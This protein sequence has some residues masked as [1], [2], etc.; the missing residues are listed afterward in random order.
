[1]RPFDRVAGIAAPLLKPNIDTDMIIRV[2]HMTASDQSRLGDHAFETWRIGPDGK[3]YPDF[4]LNQPRYRNAPILLAGANFG[5]GSSREHAVSALLG[6]GI[7]VVIA[8]DFGE[9]FYNNCFQQGLLPIRL[10]ADIIETIA[11]ET[12]GDDADVTLVDLLATSIRSPGG[13]IYRFEIEARRRDA[14]LSGRGDIEQS[15]ALAD[16]IDAWQARDRGLRPWL[17]GR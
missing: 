4:I 6:R 7:R 12:E 15:L 8:P 17:W 1:M 3:E 10:T 14:L 5:C 2:E 9:T 13:G 16:D 11:R